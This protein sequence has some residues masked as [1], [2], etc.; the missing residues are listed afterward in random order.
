MLYLNFIRKI[1]I[2]N[3][4]KSIVLVLTLVSFYFAGKVPDSKYRISVAAENKILSG[5]DTTYNYLYWSD[6]EYKICLVTFDREVRK[7]NIVEWQSYSDGNIL[8]WSGFVISCVIL[9]ILSLIPDGDIGWDFTG[10]WKSALYDCVKVVE[11]N[12]KFYWVLKGRLLKSSDS[13]SLH[14]V[15]R[16]TIDSLVDDYVHRKEI[17]PKFSTIQEKRNNKLDNLGI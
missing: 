12:D 10:C 16:Y 9:I 5:P 7:G 11:Q 15:S 14:V 1:L 17:F 3:I 6:S 13:S 4:G 8:I 2:N